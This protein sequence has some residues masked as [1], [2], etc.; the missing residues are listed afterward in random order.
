MESNNLKFKTI[1]EILNISTSVDKRILKLYF[2][3]A[4]VFRES[5]ELYK[6]ED[7]LWLLSAI[8]SIEGTFP[9][10]L[11]QNYKSN[12]KDLLLA[13]KNIC[14][15]VYEDSDVFSHCDESEKKKLHSKLDEVIEH[16]NCYIEALHLIESGKHID[17]VDDV[18][19]KVKDSGYL[20]EPKK[21]M[22]IL[23]SVF[24]LSKFSMREQIEPLFDAIIE[25]HG[26]VHFQDNYL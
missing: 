17:Y 22:R 3:K 19:R 9:V 24:V 11:V 14:L 20:Y 23:M 7:S 15:Y 25:K 12:K 6:K 16:T 4:D 18:I 1:D 8:N 10:W 26:D 5:R 21:K 2:N 13:Y